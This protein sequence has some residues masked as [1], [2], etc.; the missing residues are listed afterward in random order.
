[1]LE[2]E[3]SS[4]LFCTKVLA[5]QVAYEEIPN[6][7]GPTRSW[8]SPERFPLGLF[9]GFPEHTQSLVTSLVAKTLETC[10]EWKEKEQ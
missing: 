2:R 4:G 9:L 1:M 7:L 8:R 3:W 10:V 5:A 6:S